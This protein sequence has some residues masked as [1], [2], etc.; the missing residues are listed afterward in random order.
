M[1]EAGVTQRIL[2]VVTARAAEAEAS[3]ITEVHLEV[4]E[5][6]GVDAEAI[7]LHWPILALGTTAAGARLRVTE[8]PDPRTFR[9][10]SLDVEELAGAGRPSPD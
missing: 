8:A 2:E 3:R 9:I 7:A 5:A 6:A 4:G 10:V 1:H